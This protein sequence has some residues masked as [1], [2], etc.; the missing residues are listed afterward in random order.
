MAS[1]EERRGP[2]VETVRQTLRDTRSESEDDRPGG[3]EPGGDAGIS[4]A[5]EGA[6]EEARPDTERS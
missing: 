5:P 6:S 3:E 1:T 2:D 4:A